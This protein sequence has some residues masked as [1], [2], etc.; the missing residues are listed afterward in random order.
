LRRAFVADG[1]SGIHVDEGAT[2]PEEEEFLRN[3]ELKDGRRWFIAPGEV[4]PVEFLDIAHGGNEA[5]W[6]LTRRLFGAPLNH[7]E[8][9]A[10]QLQT[11]RFRKRFRWWPL[12][13]CSEA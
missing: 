12:F 3:T 7:D 11:E 10:E 1:L 9:H 8:S 5:A 4:R 6:A 2:L 13:Q